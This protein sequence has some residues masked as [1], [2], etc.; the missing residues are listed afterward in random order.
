MKINDLLPLFI[1]SDA[2]VMGNVMF[3][4]FIKANVLPPPHFSYIFMTERVYG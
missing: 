1:Q 2:F 3:F 4:M